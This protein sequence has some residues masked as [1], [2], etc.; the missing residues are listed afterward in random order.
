[1]IKSAIYIL[2]CFCLAASGSLSSACAQ[3]PAQSRDGMAEQGRRDLDHIK[4]LFR[5]GRIT[6]LEYYKRFHVNDITYFS[7]PQP[8]IDLNLYNIMAAK[9]LEDKKITREEF[10]YYT[11]KKI[12]ETAEKLTA[13]LR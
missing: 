6:L 8:I 5:S 9:M 12:S 2:V 11:N 13:P 7:P 4:M 1:M 10:D 3:V